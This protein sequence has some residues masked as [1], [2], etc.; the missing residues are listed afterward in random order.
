MI[1]YYVRNIEV[2]TFKINFIT[3]NH[4]CFNT[5]KIVKDLIDNNL[6]FFKKYNKLI[7]LYSTN[8]LFNFDLSYISFTSSTSYFWEEKQ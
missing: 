8:Y 4:N 7:S 2:L 1:F 3:N 5:I 6:Y